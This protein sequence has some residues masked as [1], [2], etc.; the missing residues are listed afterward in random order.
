MRM[1]YG[2]NA[3][4]KFDCTIY[5]MAEGTL[6]VTVEAVDEN[7]AY[8]VAGIAASERGCA[9]VIEVVVGVFE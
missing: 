4:M 9:N 5:D 2:A 6:H 1:D 8:E 7:D 3:G